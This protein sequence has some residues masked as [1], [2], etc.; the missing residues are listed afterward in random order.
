MG[1]L[2]RQAFKN[3][4]D[5]DRPKGEG[6]VDRFV[7]ACGG[8]CRLQPAFGLLFNAAMKGALS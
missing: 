1:I 6:I 5:Q 2:P 4:I 7:A 8:P 3:Q